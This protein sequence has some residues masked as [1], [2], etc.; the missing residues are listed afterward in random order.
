MISNAPLKD[1]PGDE[2]TAEYKG[3]QWESFRQSIKALDVKSTPVSWYLPF[4]DADKVRPALTAPICELVCALHQ[5][6]SLHLLIKTNSA[7]F[8]SPV[9]RA[10]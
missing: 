4:D 9:P 5:P 10:K 6:S 3:P 8:I 1:W 2:S 7:M